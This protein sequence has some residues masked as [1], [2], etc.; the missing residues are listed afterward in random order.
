MAVEVYTVIDTQDSVPFV[1]INPQ[2]SSLQNLEF[3]Q[4]RQ[5]ALAC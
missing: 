4:C 5:A 3:H 2:I 1:D